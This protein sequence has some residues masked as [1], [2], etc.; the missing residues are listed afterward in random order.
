MMGIWNFL[1]LKKQLLSANVVFGIILSQL[2]CSSIVMMVIVWTTDTIN[3][4]HRMPLVESFYSL[5]NSS[6]FP[7]FLYTG[8]A[9]SILL[10]CFSL[11][12]IEHW[13]R[14]AYAWG[15]LVYCTLIAFVLM[16]FFSLVSEALCDPL[17]R[18]LS[19]SDLIRTQPSNVEL[20]PH[21]LIDDMDKLSLPQDTTPEQNGICM[22]Q[23]Q[24]TQ[25]GQKF[26][27]VAVVATNVTFVLCFVLSIV[28]AEIRQ[29][30]NIVMFHSFLVIVICLCMQII[31]NEEEWDWRIFHSILFAILV[32][33]FSSASVLLGD[34]HHESNLLIRLTWVYTEV[35]NSIEHAV[36]ALFRHSS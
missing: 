25:R 22:A 24:Y 34:F 5:F 18:V 26:V 1:T 14:V 4:Y 10:L 23:T 7:T 27:T 20:L 9:L 36:F 11:K 19:S 15:F 33:T 28:Y 21:S 16:L 3:G 12:H 2:L 13:N 17:I 32:S 30:Y 35:L 6:W 31:F 29:L 8:L